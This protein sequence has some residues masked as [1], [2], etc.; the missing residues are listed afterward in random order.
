MALKATSLGSVST[1][2]RLKPGVQTL[3]FLIVS[4]VGPSAKW[5]HTSLRSAQ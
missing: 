1:S 2:R 5:R 4:P 3:R